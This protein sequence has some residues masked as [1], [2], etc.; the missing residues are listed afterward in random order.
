[1]VAGVRM[2]FGLLVFAD[3]IADADDYVVAALRKAGS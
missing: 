1:M 2:T 3:N